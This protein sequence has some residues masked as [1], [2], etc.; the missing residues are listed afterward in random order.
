MFSLD[1]QGHGQSQG[2]RGYVSSFD[3]YVEDFLL[4]VEHTRANL[5]PRPSFLLGRGMGATIAIQVMRAYAEIDE[6]RR[7]EAQSRDVSRPPSPPSAATAVRLV[8]SSSPVSSPTLPSGGGSFASSPFHGP[9]SPRGV[10]VDDSDARAALWQWQGCILISPAI[11]PPPSVSP[12]AE[13]LAHLC[14]DFLPKLGFF[15]IQDDSR[16]SRLPSVVAQYRADPLVVKAPMAARWAVEVLATMNELREDAHTIRFPFFALQG[17]EDAM[18]SPAGAEWIYKRSQSADK[19]LRVYR[20]A[21]HDLL[22]DL[23]REQV[24]EDIVRWMSD[25]L[26]K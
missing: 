21:Y 12:L 20:G 1:H 4:F 22:H 25:R 10:D 11:I 13:M 6:D 24:F 7:R 19:K 17:S 14:Y 3:D 2:D 9:H 8:R 15:S 16:L 26:D 5:E 23:N 18:V